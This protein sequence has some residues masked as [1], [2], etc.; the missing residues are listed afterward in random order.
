MV[1]NSPT[2]SA[3]L[4]R[5]FAT[6]ATVAVCLL[7]VFTLFSCASPEGE[8]GD[9]VDT[10]ETDGPV[11]LYSGRNEA[12]IG[13]LLD[14]LRDETGIDVQVRFGE[15]AE[16]AAT[17]LEEGGATPADLF[18]AQDAGALGA[19]ERAGMLKALPQELLD[20]VPAQLR[21]A[22]GGWV[23][24][25][26]RARVVVYNSDLISEEELPKSLDEVGDPKYRG[27]FGIAPTNGSLQAHLALVRAVR[28]A[29][30]LE[31]WLEKVVANEPQRYPRNSAIVEAVITGEVEWGLTNHYY[32][33]RALAENP[34][35][36][37]RNFTM[38]AD[39]DVSAFVNVAGIGT[40]TGTPEALEVIEYLLSEGAQQYFAEETYEY[41]LV[42]GVAAS[43]EL[44]PL[45]ELALP[46][47]RSEEIAEQLEPTLEAI[48]ASGLLP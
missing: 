9:T 16:M 31:A 19:V 18:L 3:S 1:S 15:T 36:P 5:S 11:V 46:Q 39:D 13:P 4:G 38:P 33:W 17:L 34:E 41:P 8:G 7:L 35:A 37:G 12:L 22:N 2:E 48:S 10:A 27:T 43:V 21:S 26:G 20:Q 42:D 44:K 14:R 24:V 23:G 6:A 30:G 47:V 25:S 40:M 45:A 28:G 29:E 32:L